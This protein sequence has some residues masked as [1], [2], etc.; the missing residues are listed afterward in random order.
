MGD[1]RKTRAY[2]HEKYEEVLSYSLA[3]QSSIPT[4]SV[5]ESGWLMARATSATATSLQIAEGAVVCDGAILSGDIIIGPET[6]VFPSARIQ[7][8]DGAG[9]IVIGRGCVVEEGASIVSM[10][11]EGMSIGNGNLFEVGCTVC[12]QQ[13]SFLGP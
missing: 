10:D 11:A 12:A 3:A 13:V 7:C 2:Q 4:L 6:V 1:S 9:P 8:M 5:G